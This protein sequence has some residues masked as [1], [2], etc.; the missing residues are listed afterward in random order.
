[1]SGLLTGLVG[2]LLG[3]GGGVIL[4]PVLVLLFHVPMHFAVGTS[5][6]VVVTTSSTVGALRGA[7]GVPNLPLGLVLELSTLVGAIGGGLFAGAIPGAVLVGL[8]G[9]VLLPIGWM[10]WQAPR[11]VAQAAAGYRVRNLKAGLSIAFLAGAISGLLGVGGGIVMVPALTLLC[12]VPT[13]VAIATS[14]FMIGLTAVASVFLYWGRG[15]VEPL[16]TAAVVLGVM[17]GSGIGLAIGRKLEGWQIR[18]VFAALL[19]LT[20]SQM[21]LR[22]SGWWIK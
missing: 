15:E 8:F 4:V 19:W 9:I 12:G 18:R 1:M 16:L 3:V 11:R 17:C 22:A 2:S 21:L 14:N 5:L 13:K 10:M 6:V 20:A 7:S